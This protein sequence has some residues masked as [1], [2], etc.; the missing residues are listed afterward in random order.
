[1]R[2]LIIMKLGG[3]VITDK[4][5]PFTARHNTIKRLAAEIR[6][7]RKERQFDVIIGHGGGSFPH[8]AATEYQTHKGA[9]NER[10]GR[11]VAMVQD[12]A[13]RLNRIV[14][15]ALLGE[16][17]DAISMQPSASCITEDGKIVAWP[18]DAMK[19]ALEMGLVPVAYGDAALDRKNGC[20]I[21]STEKL[22]NHMADTFKPEKI[23]IAGEVDG[24]F[25]GDPFKD[26]TAKL[27]PLI[28]QANLPEIRQY[29]GASRGTDVT[30]GMIDKIKELIELAGKGY[31][32]EIVNA[33]KSGFLKRA[34]LGEHVGTV[35][36]P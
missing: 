36:S 7:A 19:M 22:I 33:T 14:V 30:G 26:P 15:S 2:P 31:T 21:V 25:T 18:L 9:V 32:S 34:L 20:T 1:M 24:V 23:I 4:T 35:V 12:A 5:R 17:I 27:I 8:T 13:S 29:L 11:G 3:S 10:S 28:T 16:G 6:E